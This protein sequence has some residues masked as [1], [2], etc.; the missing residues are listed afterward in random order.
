MVAS[1]SKTQFRS[2]GSGP[3]E[4][5][6][7]GSLD[8]VL[9]RDRFYKNFFWT[10]LD[11]KTTASVR[12]RSCPLSKGISSP[13]EFGG[14][15]NTQRSRINWSKAIP[16]GQPRLDSSLQLY[17]SKMQRA[18]V[19]T[20]HP[21]IIGQEARLIVHSITRNGQQHAKEVAQGLFNAGISN[22]E[23]SRT[24]ALLIYNVFLELQWSNWAKMDE[25]RYHLD[26]LATT[27]FSNSWLSL[28]HDFHFLP[29]KTGLEATS[30][31]LDPSRSEMMNTAAF[32]GDLTAVGAI[33]VAAFSRRI[34]SFIEL[35]SSVSQCRALYLLLLR[36]SAH[37]AAPILSDD[38]IAWRNRLSDSKRNNLFRND[39]MAQRW[40]IEI[41]NIIDRAITEN[42]VLLA[43]RKGGT[44]PGAHYKWDTTFTTQGLHNLLQQTCHRDKLSPFM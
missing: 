15:G 33:D 39:E 3:Q 10:V 25:L 1:A 24:V 35:T 43:E 37:L 36:A 11:G 13:D 9:K 42:A 7:T 8:H 14:A 34:G 40:I 28:Q 29:T 20:C 26:G 27:A 44:P 4:V 19:R 6:F 41:C 17:F 23:H 38:L 12:P 2:T 18:A 22:T 16:G 31:S 5:P 21:L 30:D 32:L